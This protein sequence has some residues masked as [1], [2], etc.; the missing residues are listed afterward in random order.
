MQMVKAALTQFLV[1]EM[2][3]RRLY[4]SLRAQVTSLTIEPISETFLRDWFWLLIWDECSLFIK[5]KYVCLI[6]QHTHVALVFVQQCWS[7]R[8]WLG[9]VLMGHMG[10]R[11]MLS[12]SFFSVSCKECLSKACGS[13]VLITA[14]WPYTI[15]SACFNSLIMRCN[16]VFVVPGCTT[17]YLSVK[18]CSDVCV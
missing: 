14:S 10:V 9:E 11:L 16:V 7:E 12:V 8:R 15:L 17:R 2:I 5:C 18:Q 4:L 13:Q 6:T 1:A 3:F